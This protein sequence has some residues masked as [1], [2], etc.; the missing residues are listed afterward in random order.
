MVI[1]D[2]RADLHDVAETVIASGFSRLPVRDSA[3][4]ELT[5]VLFAKDLLAMIARE[6]ERTDWSHLV[7][8]TTLVPES[9]RVDDLL[10]DLREDQLHQALVVDEFGAVVGLVTIEDILEEIVGEIVDEHD[11]EEPLLEI[12]EDG[13]R[14]D[15]RLPLDDLNELLGKQLPED[16]WDTVGGLLMGAMGRVPEVGE[17]VELDG[18]VF[19]AESV[20]G[21]RIQK[22]HIA[23]EDT[24]AAENLDAR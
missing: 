19:T 9:R 6:P 4:D 21:R 14:V 10:T 12:T 5:G 24:G 22:I 1:V 11:H 20:Q 16:G 3:R 8:P 2:D 18:V 15:A 13:M 17:R 23:I 7:R